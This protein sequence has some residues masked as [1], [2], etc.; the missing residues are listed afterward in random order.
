MT[1]KKETKPES[2]VFPDEYK[3]LGC[4][5]SLRRPGFCLLTIK[6]KTIINVKLLNKDNKKDKKKPY[7]ELLNDI[8]ET[9][10]SILPENETVYLVRETEI[11]RQKTPAERSLSKVVGL[12][13]WAAWMCEYE[14]YSI[15]PVTIKKIITGSGTAQKD[16]VAKALDKFIG[17]Q[18]YKCDDESDAAAV[19]VAWLIQQGQIKEDAHGT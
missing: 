1:K 10:G 7:G 4:D 13:D 11:M 18:N 19:A 15:Y 9:F 8:L 6:D 12:L 17:L 16:E 14:W 5:L 3:V 2:I